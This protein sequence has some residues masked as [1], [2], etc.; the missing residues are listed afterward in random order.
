MNKYYRSKIAAVLVF[1]ICGCGFMHPN[2]WAQSDFSIQ[3]EHGK[4]YSDTLA[5]DLATSIKIAL[6]RNHGL[7]I[8]KAKKQ[9][10][11]AKVG[12]TRTNLLPKVST[13]FSYTRLDVAPFFPTS[14]FAQLM[15]GGRV[16]SGL[17][18][19][20]MPKI[21][22]IGDANNYAL[23]LSIQQPIFTGG[24]IWRGYR[25]A[26][27]AATA[28]EEN[29]QRARND[30]ITEVQQAYLGVL[31]V[32]EY[33]KVAAEAVKQMQAHLQDLQNMYDVGMVT[34]N[35]LLRT[36]VA[37]SNTKLG[38]IKARNGVRLAKVAF[39]SKIGLPLEQPI[40]LTEK[41]QIID[42]PPINLEDAIQK[43]LENRPE[44]KA[45]HNNI[46]IART[47]VAIS[48]AAYYPSIFLAANYSYRRP[49]RQYNPKFYTTWTISLVAQLNLFD[50]G[51]TAFQIEQAQSQLQ[52][53]EHA[54]KQLQDGIVLQITQTYLS[55]LEAK[56]KVETTK[57]NIQQAQENY[58][59]TNEKFKQGL[60]SNT[61]LLDANTLLT[62]AKTEYIN[63]LA[64]YRIAYA[65]LMHAI[66]DIKY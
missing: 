35:D 32:Q 48:K 39:C 6:Q 12:D 8:A 38:L 56:E 62:Q 33:E 36:K 42:L 31:K 30:L 65:N 19:G 29:C 51:Q 1:I 53:T 57:I 43:A 46:K 55:L 13:S 4:S 50:W 9:E 44:I 61:E 15:G 16:P 59:V 45:M 20:I 64:D 3:P 47:A 49:D 27:Y 14:R 24:R 54:M 10:A 5:L 40:R 58:R 41:L 37:L 21:I 60:V 23:G 11:E 28:A 2:L 34:E 7:A 25:I 66:G 18:S 63:A 26:E 52:Q 22:T 17:P